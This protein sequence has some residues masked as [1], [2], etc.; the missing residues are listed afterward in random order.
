MLRPMANVFAV[1]DADE[2]FLT[3]MEARL[4]EAG[5]FEAVWRPAPGWVAAQA[6]LPE[7]EP[8]DDL[9]RERGFA[10]IEGR[11]RLQHGKD[12]RWLD[13]VAHLADRTPG[14]LG[15]LPGDFSFLRFRPD[16][17]A[18]AVRACA[19]VAP[20]YLYRREGG[21]L[22]LGT[23]LSHFT[24]FL[25]DRFEPDPLV[26]ASW[27]ATLV[28]IDGRTFVEGIS[29]LPRGSHTA[30]VLARPPVTGIYWD[31]RPAE[32]DE[33]QQSP[34]HARELRALLVD[35]LER[36]LDP[37][38]R[39]LLSLSGGIDSCSIG[40]LAAGVVGRKLF[41]WSLIPAF[42]PERSH[43][44][45][46][47]EPLVSRFDIDPALMCELSEEIRWRW[48]NEAPG[49]P[50]NV[51][52]PVLCELP[53]IR[54]ERE[55]SVLVGGEF[56]DDVC[57]H[58]GR[59]TDWARYTSLVS[60]ARHPRSLPFGPRDCLRWGKRRLLDALGRPPLQFPDELFAW[61]HPGVQAEYRAW[62]EG[63]RQSRRHD[64]RPLKELADRVAA[65]GW[66]TMNW[67][68]ATPLGVRRSL[69]F[70][71]REML[72]LAFRC[73]PRELMGPGPKRL[74]REAL[75]D[76]VPAR[77]LFRRDKGGWGRGVTQPRDLPW[78]GGDLP[79]STARLVVPDWFV[80]SPSDVP[81]EDFGTVARALRIAKYLEATVD[82]RP[83]RS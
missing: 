65:D 17:R 1:A 57:G 21:G 8:G 68:G 32:G 2:G 55:V 75:R 4:R 19:G 3:Q 29:I 70:F 60:L 10:F 28:F 42:E 24:R 58:L 33:P 31:P 25:P 49:L 47:I 15:E 14:G 16:G 63:R 11:D 26:N 30:L 27:E 62:L 36:D 80:R 52:H 83:P 76:D 38:G 18:Q 67:E 40:A 59:I 72:E 64:D 50:F 54:A 13:R 48:I 45:S 77:N 23:L 79:P 81:P 12:L 74:L 5:E 46:Y 73:H 20:L 66:V 78:L 7:S 9:L 39:N 71:N 34:E 69:P 37:R 51:P 35:S 56:A 44:L 41:S 53:R 43:E 22:G 82:S 6:T 61:I